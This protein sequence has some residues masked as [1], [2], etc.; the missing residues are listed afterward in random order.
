[1]HC[2]KE[3]GL[4]D[5]L[6]ALRQE[7]S[8]TQKEVSERIGITKAMLSKY[9]NGINIPRADVLADLA[10]VLETSTD[11]LLCRTGDPSV[12]KGAKP[13]KQNVRVQDC[14]M[15]F[16]KLEPG[17]QEMIYQNVEC[18]YEFT[19]KHDRRKR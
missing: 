14:F 16:R 11:Y 17:F 18:L 5:R 7:K 19:A 6:C 2:E 9:E 15:K 13:D 3:N 10:D 8:L 12:P 1:M 4:G